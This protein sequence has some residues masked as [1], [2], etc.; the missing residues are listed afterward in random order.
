[1]PTLGARCGELRIVDR[2]VTWRVLY[3]VDRDA[4]VIG[5]VFAKKTAATPATVLAA[6]RTRFRAYDDAAGEETD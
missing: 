1:M 5:A 3:R 6:C 2:T 4:V